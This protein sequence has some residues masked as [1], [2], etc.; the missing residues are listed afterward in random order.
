MESLQKKKCTQS[1]RT[2]NYSNAKCSSVFCQKVS[3]IRNTANILMKL[4]MTFYHLMNLEQSTAEC[5]NL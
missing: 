2:T 4:I 5:E 3:A 1:Q